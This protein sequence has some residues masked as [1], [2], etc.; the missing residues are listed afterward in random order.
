MKSLDGAVKLWD[1]IR[2]TVVRTFITAEQQ[3]R[4]GQTQIGKYS[5]GMTM[6]Y[7][8]EGQTSTVIVISGD[9]D[10]YITCWDSNTKQ[11]LQT[12]DSGSRSPVMAASCLNGTLAVITRDGRC[13][14]YE[15]T[16]N[17]LV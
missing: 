17:K 16:G 1:C 5:C 14:I 10:G 11:I 7:I 12:L 2:G 6:S 13:N 4:Q 15:W 3:Q 8:I 9:E